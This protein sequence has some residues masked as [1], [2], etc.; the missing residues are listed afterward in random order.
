MSIWMAVSKKK[1]SEFTEFRDLHRLIN[2]DV[3]M[4]VYYRNSVKRGNGNVNGCIVSIT[5]IGRP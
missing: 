1:D 4:V 3:E 5:G 2:G